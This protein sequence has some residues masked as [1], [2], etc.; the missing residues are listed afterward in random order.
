MCH[1][2]SSR[3]GS[4]R[5][6]RSFECLG[7]RSLSWLSAAA[8]AAGAASSCRF[9]LCARGAV[10][11]YFLC[12]LPLDLKLTHAL[13]CVSCGIVKS[14]I[15]L[16][17][18]GTQVLSQAFAPP[19]M[20]RFHRT[21]DAPTYRHQHSLHCT[22]H[23]EDRG[24]EPFKKCETGCGYFRF[25]CQFVPVRVGLQGLCATCLPCRTK[26][27]RS[28]SNARDRDRALAAVED[29]AA[30]RSRSA[31]PEAH[32]GAASAAAS[33][34]MPAPVIAAVCPAMIDVVKECLVKPRHSLL[35]YKDRYMV[36]LLLRFIF[37]IPGID[38]NIGAIS[39]SLIFTS[40]AA[41]LSHMSATTVGQ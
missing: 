38:F 8:A 4:F 27:G 29:R 24:V 5:S 37:F 14:P 34:V 7:A 16:W 41:R 20:Y 9:K 1:G 32:R 31:S 33:A 39:C 13:F 23:V 11:R 28:N 10:L 35:M 22:R 18:A 17:H 36:R 12:L 40:A 6:F 15:F 26:R 19:T 3:R 2:I 25:E 21:H 30:A